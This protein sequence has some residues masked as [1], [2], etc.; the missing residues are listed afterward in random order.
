ML[1]FCLLRLRLGGDVCMVN[2]AK[3]QKQK[4]QKNLFHRSTIYPPQH[5]SVIPHALR[6]VL[7]FRVFLIQYKE[8]RRPH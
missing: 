8:G 3:L 1:Y 7:T 5:I 6:G 4:H 2:T